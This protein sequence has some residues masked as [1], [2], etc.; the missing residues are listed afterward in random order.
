MNTEQYLAELKSECQEAAKWFS[1]MTSLGRMS[2]QDAFNAAVL[3]AL[4]HLHDAVES[5]VAK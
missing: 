2:E 4:K 5:L 1:S 3:K